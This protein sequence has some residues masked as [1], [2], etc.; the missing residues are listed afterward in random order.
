MIWI[1]RKLEALWVQTLLRNISI[2]GRSLFSLFVKWLILRNIGHFR[3]QFIQW[4]VVRIER[5]INLTVR[6]Y[7]ILINFI[8]TAHFSLIEINRLMMLFCLQLFHSVSFN[9]WISSRWNP[10][11]SWFIYKLIWL[12]N[13]AMGS[14]ASITVNILNASNWFWNYFLFFS[15]SRENV[16][17]TI[18]M[19]DISTTIPINFSS[20]ALIVRYQFLSEFYEISGPNPLISGLVFLFPFI[21]NLNLTLI[22]TSFPTLARIAQT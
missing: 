9:G 17:T 22:N 1:F 19:F 15:S 3:F 5:F 16:R 14:R 6:S 20:Q 13:L 4:S 8:I 10:L 18:R 7:T 11:A 2:S 12:F 21:L